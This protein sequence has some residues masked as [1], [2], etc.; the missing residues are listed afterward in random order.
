MRWTTSWP[1]QMSE[2]D[3]QAAVEELFR[4]KGWF[5]YHAPDSRGSEPGLLDVVAVRP[6]RVLF[7]E[8]K[9][10]NGKLDTRE[11]WTWRRRLPTQAE[12]YERL[13]QCPGVETHLFRPSDWY[14]G[15]I[16][17]VAEWN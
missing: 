9:S 17:E 13:S 10:Q 16:E 1:P 3:L 8:L 4:M 6:P 15:R 5:V 11:H 14:S 2:K 7:A 12:W